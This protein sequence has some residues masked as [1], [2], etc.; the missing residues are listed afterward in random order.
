LE[1]WPHFYHSAGR[2]ERRASWHSYVLN[3]NRDI[4]VYLPPSYDENP[5]ER[6]PVV[7]MHDGTN[8]FY[9]Q[10]SFAGVSWNV[11][12]AMD[13][14]AGDATIH[15]AIIIGVY[16]DANRIW[17]MT[18]TDGGYGGGGADQYLKFI[19]D[20]LKPQIDLQ[21]RTNPDRDH[22]RILGSSLGRL[23]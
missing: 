14:G 4:L 18:P 7:Y 11:Q 15:E 6:Y 23:V 3:D 13:G 10:D 17:E 22:T 5:A 12:G 19:A 8:L 1:I 21:Y 16:S 2:I 9:D 20:E